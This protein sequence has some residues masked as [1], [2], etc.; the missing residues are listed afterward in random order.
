MKEH[1]TPK[2][3]SLILFHLKGTYEIWIYIDNSEMMTNIISKLP[4][5]YPNKL[6]ILEDE[7]DDEDDPFVLR[8]NI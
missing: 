1:G 6:E 7:L 2:N 3:I 5:E 4:E 8:D